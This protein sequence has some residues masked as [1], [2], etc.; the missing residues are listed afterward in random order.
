MTRPGQSKFPAVSLLALLAAGCAVGP[1]YH[2]PSVPVPAH[3]TELAGWAKAAPAD[4]AP[5]GDW[6]TGFKDPLLDRLEP[7]VMV[8]NQTVR[9][10][11]YNWQQARALVREAEGQLFPSATLSGTAQRARSEGLS[12]SRSASLTAST[13]A[14]TASASWE[15]DLWGGIRRQV[16]QS[17]ASA[18]QSQATLANAT[19]SAQALL[20][21]NVIELRVADAEILLLKQTAQAYQASLRITENQAAAGVAAPSDVITARAQL[22]AAQSALINAGIARAEYEHAIAVLVGSLPEQLGVPSGGPMPNLPSIP[23]SLPSTLLQRRPDIAG[24]ERAVAAANAAIGVQVAAFYPTITLTGAGGYSGGPIASLFSAANQVWS[25]GADAS[26]VLFRGGATAAAVAAAEDS[27][28]AAV[29]AYRGDV[30]AAFQQVEDQLANLRILAQQA[31]VQDAAVRDAKRAVEIAL[32]EYE[33]GTQ[34][35]TAVVTARATLLEDQQTALQI[36]LNRLLASVDLIQALGGG[37]S[38][39]ELYG[40]SQP[41]ELQ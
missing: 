15:P 30:L 33:A 12:A 27:Y 21:T 19:L 5:K 20:A 7:K 41:S 8:S 40:N 24:D 16:E 34:A 37:W 28:N 32:N 2:R 22:E 4:G 23:M 6:W 39:A 35:Y 36:R 10:D 1:N 3:Y 17:T 25:L 13:A 38:V 31:T 14:L 11:Y 9:E 29:A 26:L 18:Q